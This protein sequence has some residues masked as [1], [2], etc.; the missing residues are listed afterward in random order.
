MSAT[1]VEELSYKQASDEL[2][3]IVEYVEGADVDLDELVPKLKRAAQI[4][5]ELDRRIK[6]SKAQVETIVPRLGAIAAGEEIAATDGVAGTEG[7]TEREGHASET[8]FGGDP[9][10][11]DEWETEDG[12]FDGHFRL[13]SGM[14]DELF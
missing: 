7:V 9:D 2:N 5:T 1:S 8:A 12:T 14:D 6:S 13:G 10:T 11:A 4:V 3:A